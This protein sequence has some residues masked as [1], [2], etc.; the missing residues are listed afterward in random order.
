[1]TLKRLFTARMRLGMFD[2]PNTVPYANTPESEI[3]S[4]PHRALALKT[5]QK[6]MVLLKNDGAL[7]L[8][9]GIKKILVVGPLAESTEVLYGNYSGT[10]SHAVSVLEGIRK[11]FPRARVSYEP[12]TSFLSEKPV[13][14]DPLIAAVSA[15]RPTRPPGVRSAGDSGPGA[16]P[17]IG[18]PFPVPAGSSLREVRTASPDNSRSRTARPASV[19]MPTGIPKTR[20]AKTGGGA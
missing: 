4:T 12:G 5:A 16:S 3:D 14:G 2:P 15:A 18:R 10:P 7:P 20:R 6:S 13:S 19:V 8:R 1:V 9:E 17:G 11:Q